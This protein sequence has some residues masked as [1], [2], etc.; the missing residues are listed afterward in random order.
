VTKR[1]SANAEAMRLKALGRRVCGRCSGSGVH[2]TPNM[3]ARVCGLCGGRG[4]HYISRE[5]PSELPSCWEAGGCASLGSSDRDAR[6][7]HAAA[8]CGGG[9]RR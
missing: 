7:G 3:S 4:W 2:A 1:Q 5:S 6:S 8:F 9:Y